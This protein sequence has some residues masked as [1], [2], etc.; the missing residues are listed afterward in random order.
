MA[1]QDPSH[2]FL[3]HKSY[4]DEREPSLPISLLLDDKP[5][6]GRL[7]PRTPIRGS[8]WGTGDA[9]TSHCHVINPCT[10]V[11]TLSPAR[12]QSWPGLRN[13]YIWN[14]TGASYGRQVWQ[15]H[16][17]ALPKVGTVTSSR[18]G[19][20]LPLRHEGQWITPTQ[21]SY[22]LTILLKHI[23]KSKKTLI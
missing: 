2:T 13:Y 1:N 7:S 5:R 10:Y 23:V 4:P 17:T 22:W 20:K 11:G 9:M 3:Q 16:F 15:A 14:H 21:L 18:D 8:Y 12:A 6:L 19:G